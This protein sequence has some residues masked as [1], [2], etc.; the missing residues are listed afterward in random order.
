VSWQHLETLR[1]PQTSETR[2][3][4]EHDTPDTFAVVKFFDP[5]QK[6]K[7]TVKVFL[8]MYAQVRSHWRTLTPVRDSDLEQAALDLILRW[9]KP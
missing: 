7:A 3:T 1:N 9:L 5:V 6:E 2:V 8:G 4:F